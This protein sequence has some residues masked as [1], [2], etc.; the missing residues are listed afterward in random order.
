MRQA[1]VLAAAALIALDEGPALLRDD[2][3]RAGE[4]ARA[5]AELPGLVIDPE[6]MHT[7]IVIATTR[8]PALEAETRLAERGVLT[9]ALAPHR[10]RF[11]FHRDVGDDALGAAV[12]AAKELFG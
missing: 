1:G 5:L 12:E 10:L 9:Q 6:A 8:A 7:N 4:L 2:H 11:V 3:R